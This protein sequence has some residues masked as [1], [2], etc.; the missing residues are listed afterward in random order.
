MTDVWELVKFGVWRLLESFGQKVVAMSADT[1]LIFVGIS[2]VFLASTA[3]TWS[4]HRAIRRTEERLSERLIQQMH[5]ELI[6]R[7]ETQLARLAI[8]AGN[9][10]SEHE[11]ELT[12]HVDDG[13]EKQEGQ[14]RGHE[15]ESMDRLLASMRR[16]KNQDL[17]IH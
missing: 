7:Q 11:L 13:F 1:M 17:Q 5:Y 16:L 9:E 6:R 15:D 14:L 3:A 4:L 8:A 10:S 12:N 2:F